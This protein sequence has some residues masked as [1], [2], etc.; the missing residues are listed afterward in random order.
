VPARVDLIDS[1]RLHPPR[2]R[3]APFALTLTR[4]PKTRLLCSRQSPIRTG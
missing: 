2:P 3:L 4:H 1:E